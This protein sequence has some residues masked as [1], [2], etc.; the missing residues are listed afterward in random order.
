EQVCEICCVRDTT[1]ISDFFDAKGW[2]FKQF[3]RV[4]KLA[5]LLIRT[6]A[7]AKFFLEQ[8]F[9]SRG[10]QTNHLRCLRDTQ[11]QLRAERA[12]YY[13]YPRGNDICSCL[14]RSSPIGDRTLMLALCG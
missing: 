5:L 6:Q 10:T 9:K 3:T 14:H 11:K 1:E 2:I 4:L 12:Q 7:R 13:F 8:V